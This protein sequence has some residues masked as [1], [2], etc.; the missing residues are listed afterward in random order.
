M[1]RDE[2]LDLIALDS[3]IEG[4]LT[5][6]ELEEA[7]ND[8]VAETGWAFPVSGDFRERWTKQ[9]AK[10]NC[11]FMLWT[12]AARKFKVEQLAIGERFKHYGAIIKK[13]DADFEKV[14]EDYPEEFSDVETYKAFG[15]VAGPGLNYDI[16]GND[17]T[18]YT[19]YK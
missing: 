19:V 12:G 14:Q 11:F 7:A 16:A 4:F 8:A 9:R 5:E 3:S 13:M 17:V 18:D 1:T 15:T 2:L 6:D 10:R